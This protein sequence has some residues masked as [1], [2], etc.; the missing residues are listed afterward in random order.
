MQEKVNTHGLIIKNL[1][2]AAADTLRCVAGHRSFDVIFNRR[3]CEVRVVFSDG[4]MHELPEPNAEFYVF[5][6]NHFYESQQ[7]I[8]NAIAKKMLANLQ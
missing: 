4:F 1:R 2:A 5:F 7:S 6:D 3:T 8:A